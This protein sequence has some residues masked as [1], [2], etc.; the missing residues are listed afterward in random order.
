MYYS[1]P[2]WTD[3]CLKL[4]QTA[5][6]LV[7][8]RWEHIGD[9]ELF[10]RIEFASGIYKGHYIIIAGGNRGNGIELKSAGIYDI[11]SGRHTELPDLPENFNSSYCGGAV[12]NNYFY[13][14]CL[15]FKE[16]M[17]RINL[18][19]RQRWESVAG[20]LNENMKVIPMNDKIFSLSGYQNTMYNP[21]T[22]HWVG[23]PLMN[24][25]RQ[26]FSL[27]SLEGKIYAI[28]G[29]KLNEKK[30][31]S[32]IEI[33]DSFSGTWHSGVSL[34]QSLA[35]VVAFVVEKWI[36]V[37]GG[38]DENDKAI[39][40]P[41]IFDTERQKW[42]RSTE[43]LP[44][45]RLYHALITTDEK[46]I[47]IGGCPDNRNSI[48]SLETMSKRCL[49]PNLTTSDQLIKLRRLLEDERATII[50]D[51]KLNEG[52]KIVQKAVAN[53]PDELFMHVLSF[54]I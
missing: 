46:V 9:H 7:N 21:S 22:K 52:D 34:P 27:A 13:V 3:L 54:S 23:L 37:A 31:L 44:S 6:G 17:Y 53:L 24:T 12:L 25:P 11:D 36:I 16:S 45:P 33:F 19:K 47:S 35:H 14:Y 30:K 41:L 10:Q 39:N 43:S 8:V 20:Y 40:Y 4:A 50:H 1:L 26:D 2:L 32:S 49:I 42:F 48:F 38:Q 29:H 51:E 28:G 15:Y 18:S 5:A